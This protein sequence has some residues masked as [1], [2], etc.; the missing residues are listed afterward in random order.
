MGA[1]GMMSRIGSRAASCANLA[2]SS[3]TWQ[4]D[5]RSHL[6]TWC[7]L[8]SSFS[9]SNQRRSIRSHWAWGNRS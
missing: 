7:V 6:K 9:A 4:A 2:S 1:A 5:S 3:S 8:L